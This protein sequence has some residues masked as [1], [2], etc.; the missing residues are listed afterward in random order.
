MTLL[1]FDPSM[2]EHDTGQHPERA[3]RLV[4]VVS[5]LKRTGLW[6]QFDRPPVSRLHRLDDRSPHRALLQFQQPRRRGACRRGDQA[7]QFGRVPPA[8]LRVHRRA[9][10]HEQHFVARQS[11]SLRV[12]RW[13]LLR[14]RCE[15][16]PA[17]TLTR[18]T[19]ERRRINSDVVEPPQFG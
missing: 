19:S 2:L 18:P 11:A 14:A 10:A 9:V 7:A 16:Q 13:P 6:E 17:R 12:T 4:Q 3:Q 5:H 8:L 1:Y 15:L